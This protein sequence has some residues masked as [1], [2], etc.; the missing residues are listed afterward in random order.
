VP[1]ANAVDA[2]KVRAECLSTFNCLLC[3]S[4][5]FSHAQHAP[6]VFKHSVDDSMPRM[7]CNPVHKTCMLFCLSASARNDSDRQMSEKQQQTRYVSREGRVKMVPALV[8]NEPYS[9]NIAFYS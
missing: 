7:G 4:L 6:F 2:D 5:S 1:A 3:S 8:L 9:M